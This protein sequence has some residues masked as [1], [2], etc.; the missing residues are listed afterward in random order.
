MNLG[1]KESR[2]QK[3]GAG[4]ALGMSG[5]STVEMAAGFSAIANDGVYLEPYAF[6]EVKNSDGSTYIDVGD[7]QISRQVFSEQTC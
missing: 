2:I 3:T 1:I 6:T 7:V 4:L 5:I